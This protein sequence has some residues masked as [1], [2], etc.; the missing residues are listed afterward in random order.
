MRPALEFPPSPWHG[1][2]TI[3]A[4]AVHLY[5]AAGGVLAFFALV[6]TAAGRFERALLLLAVAFVVDGTDGFMARRLRVNEVLPT[7]NGEI[8]DL[9]IDFITYAVAPLFLLW[10]AG[11]LPEPAW[12]WA[13]LILIA[14]HYDFANSHPLKQLGLYTG[15]PAMW[16]LYSFHVYY[17]HPSEPVQIACITGLF[18]LTF[19]PVHFICQSRL[20][21][22]RT[23][24]LAAVVIYMAIILAVL[25]GIVDDVRQWALLA[26]AYPVWYLG[27][28]LWVDFRFRRGLLRLVPASSTSSGESR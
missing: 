7:I 14:A 22:L 17:L 12:L 23:A 20:G 6:E 26:L 15:L 5:T 2:R 9:V 19:A 1:L 25:L 13:T 10:C 8:L 3:G 21:Y 18:I 27:S 4:A 24:S 11:L 16:N 28:S